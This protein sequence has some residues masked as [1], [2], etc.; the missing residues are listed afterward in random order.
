[1]VQVSA[2]NFQKQQRITAHI[3]SLLKGIHQDTGG[4]STHIH[5]VRHP[6]FKVLVEMGDKIIPYLFYKITQSGGSWVYFLLLQE[7]TK[8]NPAKENSGKFMHSLRDWL[9]WY[10]ESKYYPSDIY[11]GLVEE[12]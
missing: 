4:R 10:I 8:E 3:D 5:T 9:T 7:I 6:N 11:F 12:E 1:M 2:E